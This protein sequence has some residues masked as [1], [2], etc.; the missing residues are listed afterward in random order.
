MSY[1]IVNREELV[2]DGDSYE[3]QGYL[4]GDS[5]LSIILVDVPPGGGPKLHK[6]P[7]EEIF[8][9]QEGQATYTI[10]ETTLEAKAGQIAI[11]PAG[12]PHKFVNSGSGR[13]RQVDIHHSA[14]FV[15]EWLEE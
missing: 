6:H 5:N 11:V 3:F 13:L 2:R 7:Y 14:R 1:T 4:H 15:T 12:V 10:G 9:L 8:I